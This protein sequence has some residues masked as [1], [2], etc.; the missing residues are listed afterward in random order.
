MVKSWRERAVGTWKHDLLGVW[1]FA[2]CYAPISA[3]LLVFHRYANP[4]TFLFALVVIA[5]RMNALFVVAHESW[6][7][8]VFRSRRLNEWAGAGL[9]SYVIVKPYFKDRAGHWS[10]HRYVGTTRDPDA[11]S[12]DYADADRRKFARDWLL[13]ATGA[14]NI[15]RVLRV[16]L[17]RPAPGAGGPGA[18]GITRGEIVRL[19]LVQLVIV[20]LFWK[21]VGIFWYA[22]LWLFPS[23]ALAPAVTFLREFLEHRRG[24]ITIYPRANAAERFLFGCFN[25]H[26]HGY[27]HAFASAPWFVLPLVGDRARRKV[28]DMVTI[29]SYFGELFAYAAGRSPAFA[30]PTRAAGGVREAGDRPLAERGEDE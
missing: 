9:A 6:H 17:G 3:A 28:P 21:T 20:G 30:R 19:G 26:L 10:H 15:V 24:A 8:N 4:G 23:L 12:W 11:V 27:H 7:F 14:S 22:P 2:W 5:F 1:M 29:D 16:L 18:P 13:M 25:F